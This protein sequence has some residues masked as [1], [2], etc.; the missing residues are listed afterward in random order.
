[1][2]QTDTEQPAAPKTRAK[3][4]AGVLV[5]EALIVFAVTGA[6]SIAVGLLPHFN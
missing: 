6:L 3:T 1:M 4:S 2:G 5:R